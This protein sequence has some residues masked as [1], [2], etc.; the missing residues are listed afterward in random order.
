MSPL[1]EKR[2][3]PGQKILVVGQVKEVPIILST[4]G[5]STRFDLIVEANGVEG[6]EEDFSDLTTSPEEEAAIKAIAADPKYIK[7]LVGSVAPSIYGLEEIK[8]AML[9]QLVGGVARNERTE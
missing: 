7:N 2:T 1:S 9:M 5:Q 4:G 6:L 8:E 3:N